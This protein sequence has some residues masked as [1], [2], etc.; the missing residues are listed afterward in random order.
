M[1]QQI[2]QHAL[3]NGALDGATVST[4]AD[5]TVHTLRSVF[6]EL[7][8]LVGTQAVRALYIRS[9]HVTRSSFGGLAR[10]NAEGIEEQLS[11]LHGDLVA[12]ES[13]EALR[14]S[15]ALLQTLAEL[16]ISLIGGPLT[17]R[18]LRSAWGNFVPDALTQESSP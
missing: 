8:P 5:V 18:L 15:H 1:P 6:A 3:G 10:G 16:L 14:A 2:I 4:I 17:H 11:T 13:N 9:L 7:D 12:F